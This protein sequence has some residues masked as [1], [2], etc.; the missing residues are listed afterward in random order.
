MRSAR[1]RTVRRYRGRIICTMLECPPRKEAL[2]AGRCAGPLIATADTKNS[3][4]TNRVR[5]HQ[6]YDHC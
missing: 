3:G 6:F 1:M 2:R 5:A 4:P